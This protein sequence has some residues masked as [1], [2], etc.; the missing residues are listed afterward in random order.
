M[1]KVL[2]NFA[3]EKTEITGRF[4]NVYNDLVNSINTLSKSSKSHNVS[5]RKSK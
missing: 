5:P 3:P 1:K 2:S 4:L